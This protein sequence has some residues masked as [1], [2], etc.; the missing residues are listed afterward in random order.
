MTRLT[1]FC[2]MLNQPTAPKFP[3]V[4]TEQTKWQKKAF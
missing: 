3:L 2:I 4:P 1:S